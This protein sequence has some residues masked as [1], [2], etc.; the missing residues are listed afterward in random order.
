[1]IK[2]YETRA[3]ETGA[4][5]LPQSGIESGPSDLLTWTLARF[6]QAK[7]SAQTAEVVVE[8]HEIK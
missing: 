3:K 6:L 8:V 7:L 5:L 4:I 2:K 1:M